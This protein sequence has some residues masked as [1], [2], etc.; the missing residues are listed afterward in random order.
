MG[1]LTPVQFE[2]TP[3]YIKLPEGIK[4]ENLVRDLNRPGHWNDRVTKRSLNLHP[5]WRPEHNFTKK[6]VSVQEL[7][8]P[9][10]EVTEIKQIETSVKT[11]ETEVPKLRRRLP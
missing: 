11:P 8:E 10:P 6:S 1:N 9:E 2:Y 7:S 5:E 4:A 3:T